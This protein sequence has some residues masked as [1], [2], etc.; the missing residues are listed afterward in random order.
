[1]VSDGRS[2]SANLHRV[3]PTSRVVSRWAP[4]LVWLTLPLVAGPAFADALDPRST[5]V[6]LVATFGLWA[7]WAAGLVAAL[8]PSTASLTAIRIL[9]PASL[10]A[11]AW[12]A[13]VAPHGADAIYSVP[14][15]VTA[16]VSV[17]SMS[18][19]VGYTFVNGSSYGDERRFPLRP[20]G[21]VVLGPLEILWVV[22]VLGSFAGPILLATRQWLL[23]GIVTVVALAVVVLGVRAIHQLSR[24]WFVFVPAGVVLVDRSVLLDALLVQ[25]QR[26]GTIRAAAADTTATDLTAG[27]LGMPLEL[28]LTE[29]DTIIPTPP[30][31]ERHRTVVPAEVDAV[32]FTPT[33]PGWVIDA[34]RERRLSV[35]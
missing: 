5:A 28:R 31:S 30:R 14:L 32:L 25:R 3:T 11:T 10:A 15:G 26:V 35:G 18:A 1:M 6:R 33:R 19:G 24:R 8:V 17:L 20:P 7:L 16:L 23:G 13:L 4:A 34:A 22:M 9:M 21:P 27:A 12:A 2:T 29:P